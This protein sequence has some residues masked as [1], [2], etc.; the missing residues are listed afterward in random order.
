MGHDSSAQAYLARRGIRAI[1]PAKG[2]MALERTL[3]NGEPHA[4]VADVEWS[5]FRKGFE[6]WGPRA[7]LAE[8]GRGL[9]E[10]RAIKRSGW[11]EELR[12]LA[13]REREEVVLTTVRAEVARVLS[14]AGAEAV[15]KD[16]PLKELGL[17]SL[18]AVELRNA[19]GRRVGKTLPATLAFDYPTPAAM[20]KHLLEKVLSVGGPAVLAAHDA[21]ASR[22]MDEPIAI[23]GIGCRYPG[24][25]TDPETF[26]RLLD[27]GIDGVTEVPA[28]R[29]N[30]DAWYD[31]DPDAA[32]KMVT[33]WG[34]FLSGLERFEPGF[35]GM[36]A[37]EAVSVDPQLRLMLETTW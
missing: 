35:F 36:S 3:L 25:V 30:I 10:D 18:M 7:L 17:D 21:A 6:A 32:G 9:E 33:R 28:E 12:A 16:R 26:W 19:L 22:A 4:V 20:A 23:V 11:A 24:G 8:L 34:G 31:A 15:A 5:A 2:L 1:D 29:W 14:M 27:E 37:R 13:P